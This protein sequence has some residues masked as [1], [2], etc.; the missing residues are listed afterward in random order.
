MIWLWRDDNRGVGYAVSKKREEREILGPINDS[1]STSANHSVLGDREL[2][3]VLAQFE[4]LYFEALDGW[5][6]TS[7][8]PDGKVF[9]RTA[10]NILISVKKCIG[11]KPFRELIA[12]TPS[13]AADALGQ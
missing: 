8:T 11:E 4:R 3:R 5:S 12:K 13:D 7:T 1:V 2:V 9:L 6:K 10:Q